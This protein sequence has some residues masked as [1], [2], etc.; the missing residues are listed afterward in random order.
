C[1][2]SD[3]AIWARAGVVVDPASGD[4]LVATG[5]G[6]FDGVRYWGDSVL[7]LSPDA[8]RLLR[9]WTPTNQADLDS[10]DVDLGSTAPALLGHGLAVQSGNDRLLRVLRRARLNGTTAAGPLQRRERRAATSVTALPPLGNATARRGC[11][12][13]TPA[14]R[15][16][17]R[18]PAAGSCRR[19]RTR[20]R[21]RVRTPRV[22]S[23]GSTTPRVAGSARGTRPRAPF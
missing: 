6:A 11:S 22:A 2:E 21:A 1:P 19:G 10:G 15:G 17:T 16:W 5:N 13:P 8:A 9:N 7:A 3:S 14:A 18:S 4:L 23:S 20:R 12:S